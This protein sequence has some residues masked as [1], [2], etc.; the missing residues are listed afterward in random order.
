MVFIVVDL[1]APLA[2][3]KD[4]IEPCGTSKLISFK[5]VICPYQPRCFL[6]LT[7]YA[8]SFPKY[9]SITASLF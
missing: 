9:A 8:S 2:P 6:A 7:Y 3:I 4:T 1:P 5:A